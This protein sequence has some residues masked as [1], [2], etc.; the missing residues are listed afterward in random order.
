[1][2]KVSPRIPL[3]RLIADELRAEIIRIH[4]PGDRFGSQNEL[5][6]RFG[7]SHLTVRE[8]ISALVQ[9][10][11]LE[12]RFGSG[13]YVSDFN[14]HMHVGILTELDLTCPRTSYF[15]IHLAL[16]TMEIL[17]AK[18][19]RTRLYIGSTS[20]GD[21]SGCPNAVSQLMP[22]IEGGHV[23]GLIIF[24][25]PFVEELRRMLQ[26]K[27]IPYSSDPA[28]PNPA[29]TSFHP[30]MVKLG[31][32]TLL[33]E[34]CRR[35]A[36]IEH[37][38]KGGDARNRD[39]F[40]KLISDAGLPVYRSW[41][42]RAI[43]GSEG[44]SRRALKQIWGAQREKPDGFLVLDDIIYREISPMFLHSGIRLP[45]DLVVVAHANEGDPLP[46][47]PSP[48]RILVDPS[49]CAEIMVNHLLAKLTGAAPR[50]LE[51]VPLRICR[52]V[53]PLPLLTH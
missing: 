53:S 6:R 34:G 36:F 45:E 42:G 17:E 30:P 52:S 3:H 35:I 8:A 19:V 20:S 18:G 14:S 26:E 50:S 51:C 1:M 31:V 46:M 5:A 48:I 41:I 25:C 44:D 23:S 11:L 24:S 28:W 15:Y 9:E 22:E 10:G 29:F 38:H 47:S 7:V 13:T 39:L 49:E 4:Q 32:E 21:E 40:T 43:A 2:R 33:G 16:K 27:G 37:G 12:R